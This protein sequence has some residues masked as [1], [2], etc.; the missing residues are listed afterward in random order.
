[1]ILKTQEILQKTILL[2]N[3]V[4]KT[5]PRTNRRLASNEQPGA[6]RANHGRDKRS[7][8]NDHFIF[9]IW[10][11]DNEIRLV[12]RIL[13]TA[14]RGVVADPVSPANNALLILHCAVVT[15]RCPI[16]LTTELGAAR[17]AVLVGGKGSCSLTPHHHF[18]RGLLG[19]SLEQWSEKLLRVTKGVVPANRANFLSTNSSGG[20]RLSVLF[21]W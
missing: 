11:S 3:L 13:S 17:D 4:P 18:F 20:H 9:C 16:N 2:I 10:P 8:A 1:M 14:A 7:H 5:K 12:E 19:R 6:N 15:I 21:T